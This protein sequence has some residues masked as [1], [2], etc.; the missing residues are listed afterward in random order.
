M[1]ALRLPPPKNCACDFHRTQSKPSETWLGPA[2]LKEKGF[3][4]TGASDPSV[5][6]NAGPGRRLLT[7]QQ[8]TSLRLAVC[9]THTRDFVLHPNDQSHLP[10]VRNLQPTFNT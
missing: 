9:D 6:G 8:V 2:F 4:V 5:A 7:E 3:V 10:R 1:R